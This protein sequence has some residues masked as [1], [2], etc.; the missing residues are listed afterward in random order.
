VLMRRP[1]CGIAIH[2]ASGA[3]KASKPV[4]PLDG[5]T[6]AAITP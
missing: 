5:C 1:A 2:S 6:T 3:G 4:Q